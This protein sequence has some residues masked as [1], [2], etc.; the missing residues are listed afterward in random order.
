MNLR[1][2]HFMT[3]LETLEDFM[4][5][6]T[7]PRQRGTIGPRITAFHGC[8]FIGDLTELEKQGRR[9]F[10][11]P[12]DIAFAGRHA[13]DQTFESVAQL[14]RKNPQLGEF[15]SR[16]IDGLV[17]RPTFD[18][19]V[20]V[21]RGGADVMT[22]GNDA[23]RPSLEIINLDCRPVDMPLGANVGF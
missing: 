9:A 5:L 19:G 12:H 1:A 21:N 17:A 3:A 13:I 16:Q 6:L 14:A 23:E 22:A 2:G 10:P 18:L 11:R 20:T 4:I 8:D 15:E 7:Q